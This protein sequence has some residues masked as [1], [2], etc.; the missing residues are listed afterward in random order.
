MRDITT[1]IVQI[2]NSYGN[3]YYLPYSAG[4]LASYALQDPAL[5]DHVQLKPFIYKREAPTAIADRI[6]TVDLLAISCY[7]WNW[8]LSLALAAEVKRRNPGC[9]ILMGG[10][11]I[12]EEMEDFFDLYPFIDLVVHG[13]GEGAFQDILRAMVTDQPLAG[14][15]NTAVRTDDGIVTTAKRPRMRDL[16]DLPS[17]YLDGHFEELMTSEQGNEWM[18]IWETNRGCPFSCTFCD[19]GSATAS[20]VIELQGDRLDQEIKWFSDHRIRFIF[21]ADANFGIRKRDIEIARK[22]VKAKEQNGYP[23]DFRV[24]FTK[25]STEKIFDAAKIFHDA[26]MLRGISISMQS[27]NEETLRSIKRDNIKLSTFSDLQAKYNAADISTYT[28]LILGLPGETY[29]SFADGID[30]LLRNGQHSQIIVYNC[31]V[32]PNAEMGSRR[33]R[34][35]H[36]IAMVEIPIFTAHSTPHAADDPVVEYEP[37]ITATGTMSTADWRRMHRMSWAV[38]TMHTLGL[39][40]ALALFLFHRGNVAYRS[41]YEA[42][43]QDGRD[44]PESP[45]GRELAVLDRVLDRVLDGGEFG[46]VLPEYS[47]I[48]W[49]PEEASILRLTEDLP[50]FYDQV[51]SVVTRC[52]A[53]TLSVDDAALLPDIRRYQMA[54]IVDPDAPGGPQELILDAQVHE[55]IV[56]CKTG[57]TPELARGQIRYI[58]DQGNSFAGDRRRYAREIVW[59]GRKGGRY[60]YNVQ[61]PAGTETAA[62]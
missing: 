1:Q 20:K 38:Q 39:T 19:W 60:L 23:R 48:M 17:P 29:N 45:I 51:F 35:E 32:M 3:Q 40:Q 37:I 11:Q 18:A 34:A 12:P 62:A 53:E 50:G 55:F 5:R 10:P 14:I 42:L 26:S 28:E 8:R 44:N 27:L 7:V 61:K 16:T 13:E 21:C 56:A 46:Q 58:V 22:L 59:Y 57:G 49:P 47:E 43:V 41:F 36:G 31:T 9:T 6:G 15:A 54:I 52:F 33:Y 25:N 4:V 30:L 24:C 2:N